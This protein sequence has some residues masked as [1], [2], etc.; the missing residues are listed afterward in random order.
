MIADSDGTYGVGT[1]IIGNDLGRFATPREAV[2]LAFR[3]PPSAGRR[4][5]VWRRCL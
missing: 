4:T 3:H 2:A 5:N 1:D